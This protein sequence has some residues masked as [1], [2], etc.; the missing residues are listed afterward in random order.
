MLAA[1]YTSQDFSAFASKGSG[2]RRSIAPVDLLPRVHGFTRTVQAKDHVFRQ[3]D[4][5]TTVYQVESGHVC[6]YRLLP[7]GR[8]Q[9]VDFAYPGDY[10][11]LGA[12]GRHAVSAQ[13]TG[14]TRLKAVPL[15]VFR[16][17]ARLD[18]ELS[19]R[20]YEAVSQELEAARDLLVTVC[21]RTACERVASFI[22]ALSRR[23]ERRGERADELVLPMTRTDIADFLGLTIETVSRTITKLRQEKV[24]DLEQCI[25]VTIRDLDRLRDMSGGGH[26]DGRA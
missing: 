25:L 26:H 22:L 6:L 12:V 14:C 16:E 5:V 11:G 2:A 24:I 9:V 13:A 7:D 23:N 18:P 1:A 20:L 4:T 8:R 21:Q 17:Q 19:L 10:V 15:S 3:G